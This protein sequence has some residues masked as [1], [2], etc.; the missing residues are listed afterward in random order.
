MWQYLVS[1]EV[2]DVAG[3]GGLAS[4]RH[5]NVLQRLQE[6]WPALRPSQR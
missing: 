1:A 4:L 6:L 5:C 3:E 2:G